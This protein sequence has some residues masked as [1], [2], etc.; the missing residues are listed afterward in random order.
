V[1]DVARPPRLDEIAGCPAAQV[2]A[3]SFSRLA[4]AARQAGI[5]IRVYGSWMWQ[6]LSG[7]GHVRA[8]SDLDLLVDVADAD[9]AE[10]VAAFLEREEAGLAFRLDGELSLAGLGEVQW[11]EVRQGNAEVVVKSIDALRLMP[12]AELR[13]ELWA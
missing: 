10:R 6:A 13:R 9:E 3:A 4:T 1:V 7:E 2:H 11:R 8:G 12:R 5:D